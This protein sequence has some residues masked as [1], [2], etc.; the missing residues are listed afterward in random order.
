MRKRNGPRYLW[1][2]AICLNQADEA[3]KSQQIPLMGEIYQQADKTLFWVGIEDGK[4]IRRI[5]ACFRM[6]TL[7]PRF[8]EN[9][10]DIEGRA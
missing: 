6:L 8:N 9:V 5:F 1:I 3:E 10:E 4:D 2:D 7:S